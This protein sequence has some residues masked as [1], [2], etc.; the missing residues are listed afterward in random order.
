MKHHRSVII[1]KTIID[2]IKLYNIIL[3]Y[4]YIKPNLTEF[5]L[6]CSEIFIWT[7]FKMYNV[8]YYVIKLLLF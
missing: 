6:I 3:Y 8:C 7:I 4:I 5:V 2:I 1:Y